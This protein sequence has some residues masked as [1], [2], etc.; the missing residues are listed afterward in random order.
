ME[1]FEA[2]N[3]RAHD[4]ENSTL[5]HNKEV[6]RTKKVTPSQSTTHQKA[7]PKKEVSV[8]EVG[9]SKDK[10]VDKPVQSEQKK[11]TGKNRPSLK[12]RMEKVY[13]FPK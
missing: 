11:N 7:P 4:L 1:T 10:Q 2:L 6:A 12:E 3:R 5:R 8:V 9:K 13:P